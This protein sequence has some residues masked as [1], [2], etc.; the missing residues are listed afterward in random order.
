MMDRA[1][2]GSSVLVLGS[3]VSG[4]TAAYELSRAG[5]AVTVI[6]DYDQPGGNHLS[7]NIGAYTFDIGAIFFWSNSLMLDV[8]PSATA[9]WEPIECTTGRV[10][11]ARTVRS[12]PF[13]LKREFGNLPLPRKLAILGDVAWHR[14]THFRKRS[15]EDFVVRRLGQRLYRESGLDIYIRRFCGLPPERVT[16]TFAER[17]MQ[18]LRQ[19]TS[20]SDVARGVFRRFTRKARAPA[21]QGFARPRQGFPH[22]YDQ[23]KRQ[24]EAAGVRFS[25]GAGLTSITRD[26]GGFAV[27][28]AT[29]T[30][31]GDRLIS[32]IPLAMTA[33]LAGIDDI[34]P[35]RS[36]MMTTLFC[37]FR[38]TPGFPYTVLY[39]FHRDGVWKRLTMHSNYYGQVGGDAY[40]SVE[41]TQP[42]EA[43]S[44]E[45][46]FEDFRASTESFGLFAGELELVGHLETE[47]AYPVLD[48]ESARN[49]E[50]MLQRTEQ[51]GIESLGRQGAFDYI[52]HS[53]MAIGLARKALAAAAG[54]GR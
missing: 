10:T 20:V 18:W 47:F 4:L 52:P 46:L 34:A 54:R 44:P 48:E 16:Y 26:G 38:G 28:G 5:H 11:P 14:L 51:M 35:P 43:Q 23:A 50:V 33:R 6:D 53:S 36:M 30:W 8:F 2:A 7:C 1:Q 37:R 25:L 27:T 39:N 41:C 32:T 45:A 24:L 29:G 40:F 42:D 31:R 19:K 12:Y 49:R 13:D 9:T 21:L 22:M 15:V 17:R 3:G